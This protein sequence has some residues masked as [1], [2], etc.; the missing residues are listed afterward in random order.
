[1]KKIITLIAVTA[2]IFSFSL[3][4]FAAE[5]TSAEQA[6]ERSIA[7]DTL[8]DLTVSA[9]ETKDDTVLK[10]DVKSFKGKFTDLLAELNKLR[11][12]CKGLWTQIKETNQSIKTEWNSLKEELKG[13]DRDEAKKVLTDLKAEIEPLRTQAKDLRTGISGLRTEKKSEW[14]DFRAAVK[15]KDEAKASAALNSIIDLKKQIISK[16]KELLPVKQQILED[17]KD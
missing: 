8:S 10:S 1:M 9:A 11:V 16:Q 17:V 5:S 6:I 12:E 4:A 15:S 13:K 14:T 2:V 3:P 7:E